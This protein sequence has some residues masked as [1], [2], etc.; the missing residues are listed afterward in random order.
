M[1]IIG[2][3]GDYPVTSLGQEMVPRRYFFEQIC[4]VT[5]E[6]GAT[7]AAKPIPIARDGTIRGRRA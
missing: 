6:L 3:H 4:G 1:L 5:A 2:E 7:L